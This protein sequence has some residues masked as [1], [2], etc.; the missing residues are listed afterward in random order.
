MVK[1]MGVAK[2]AGLYR[3]KLL[4]I[5]I[6][7]PWAGTFT[8][9]GRVCQSSPVTG[10]DCGMLGEPGGLVCFDLLNRHLC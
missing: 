10:R 9:G 1:R 6:V 5:K 2:M 8:V 7:S 3:E 4:G